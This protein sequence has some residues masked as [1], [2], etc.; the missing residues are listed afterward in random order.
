M[1]ANSAANR[2]NSNTVP[3]LKL[4]FRVLDDHE[5]ELEANSRDK[6]RGLFKRYNKPRSLLNVSPFDID[7]LRWTKHRQELQTTPRLGSSGGP[8]ESVGGP[9]SLTIFLDCVH[10]GIGGMGD[11]PDKVFGFDP[12]YYVRGREWEWVLGIE[13]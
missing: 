1:I 4:H 5:S 8:S 7:S 9:D 6:E 13:S 10:S 12:E 11:G 2:E 3:A